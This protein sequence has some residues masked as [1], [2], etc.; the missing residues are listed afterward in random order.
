[1]AFV[2][3]ISCI[4][5]AGLA[6]MLT[7]LAIRFAKT[8]N[9]YDLPDSRKVHSNPIPR[10][11]GVAIFLASLF[12]Y[13]AAGLFLKSEQQALFESTRPLVMGATLMFL[14]GFW[15]DIRNLSAKKK[16]SFELLATLYLC[17]SGYRVETCVVFGTEIVFPVWFSWALSIVWIVGLTNAINLTD[18]LDGLAAG[19][20]A[21]VCSFLAIICFIAGHIGLC[22]LLLT[23]SGSL[24]GFLVFNS[25]PAKIFLGD[26]GSLFLGFVLA[27]TS[28]MIAHNGTL[29][30]Y[31]LLLASFMLPLLDTL[32]IMFKRYIDR[33]SIFSPD[34][35]HFHHRLLNFGC[36]HQQAVLVI[37]GITFAGLLCGLVVIYVQPWISIVVCGSLMFAVLMIFN[38]VG[39]FHLKEISEGIRKKMTLNSQIKN[40]LSE[41]ETI[42]LSFR[43]AR[44]LPEWWNASC[45]AAE[46]LH[47]AQ[48]T[49]SIDTSAGT[50]SA[51]EWKSKE[52][53]LM[54]EGLFS[55]T[56][57]VLNQSGGSR[58][59]LRVDIQPNRS[60]ESSGRIMT[61]FSRLIDKYGQI[62]KPDHDA[63][64]IYGIIEQ[65]D[66]P[67][68]FNQMVN[69]SALV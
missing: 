27:G 28:I 51:C 45:L 16:L 44:T 17:S 60:F 32:L 18:G 62:Q 13:F 19:V 33:R 52:Y 66:Q 21:M 69:E 37:Y 48:L 23:V 58:Y 38:C 49:L 43:R 54:T 34:Q 30:Q 46:R 47:I 6:L 2:Y 31:M 29:N 4:V 9:V 22:L 1:M 14:V 63:W 12:S 20:S 35:N 3:S 64:L 39:A 25:N 7:P 55:M 68:E 5:S 36:R 67:V 11:G 40:E 53:G 42:E 10:L 26:S 41:Y 59:S 56:V 57:P 61:L 24:M 15:D 8:Y 50:I 65:Q